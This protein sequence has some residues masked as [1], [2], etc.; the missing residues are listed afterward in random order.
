MPSSQ[1]TAGLLAKRSSRRASGTSSRSL[2]TMVCEQN[3]TSRGSL[4]PVSRPTL[5]LVHWRCASIR[6]TAAIGTPIAR[7]AA[8]ASPSNNGS[9]AVSSTDRLRRRATR[10]S[11]LSGRG[12]GMAGYPSLSSAE[13]SMRLPE[14][15]VMQPAR[16]T[17][18]SQRTAVAG[19]ELAQECLPR[20]A[21]IDLGAGI[22]IDG[23]AGDATVFVAHRRPRRQPGLVGIATAHELGEVVLHGAR[24]GAVDRRPGVHLVAVEIAQRVLDL[25]TVHRAGVRLLARRGIALGRARMGVVVEIHAL[26]AGM[27]MQVHPAPGAVCDE[28]VARPRGGRALHFLGGGARVQPQRLVRAVA[29]Q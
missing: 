27:P 13:F 3:A 12:T 29:E 20:G 21:A 6:F 19:Q 22:G 2:A 7:A 17:A 18:T 5:A 16:M 26:A 9:G 11:S 1:V 24:D 8:S 14:H 25:A 23:L 15:N 4:L 10:C 28:Q